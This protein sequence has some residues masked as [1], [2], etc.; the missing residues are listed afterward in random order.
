M[1]SMTKL[2]TGL[3]SLVV[4]GSLAM[5]VSAATGVQLAQRVLLHRSD[6][7]VGYSLAKSGTFPNSKA[8]QDPV[9][10]GMAVRAIPHGRLGAAIAVYTASGR[11]TVQEYA[12][13]FTAPTGCHWY[14]GQVLKSGLSG[15]RVP[16]TRVGD[17]SV[18][19]RYQGQSTGSHFTTIVFQR[20]RYVGELELIA[21]GPQAPTAAQVVHLA[22]VMATRMKG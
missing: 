14:Y 15:K 17:Q 7:P 10:G 16:A 2:V 18:V 9:G 21:A 12:A 19:Y 3:A 1:N 4:L 22:S 8:G 11:P 13:A 20:G 5:P 6:L